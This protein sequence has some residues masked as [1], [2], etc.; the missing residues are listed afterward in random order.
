V[1]DSIYKVDKYRYTAIRFIKNKMGIFGMPDINISAD[2]ECEIAKEKGLYYETDGEIVIYIKHFILKDACLIS[3]DVQGSEEYEIKHVL[4]EG[5]YIVFDHRN[6]SY[7]FQIEI[8]GLKGPTRTLY[9]HTI[10]RENG[11]TLRVEENDL[12]RCAGKYSKDTY[13]QNQIDAASH[14]TFAAREVLRKMGVA[15][16]LHDNKLGY[17]LLLGFETCNELHP[18]Y[19][20]HWHLIFRWPYFCGS[21]APHI[22]LNEEG[23]MTYNVTYIDGIS[24]VCRKYQT[25]EWCKFV[26]MYGADVLAFRIVEDGG[27]ELTSPGGNLYKISSYHKENGVNVYCDGRYKGNLTLKND[28]VKG[29]L[30]VLWNDEECSNDSYTESIEYDPYIGTIMKTEVICEHKGL[31]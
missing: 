30:Q 3:V 4:C 28:T 13:P 2:F 25:A 16:Y 21:Q 29:K 22:Y 14:Y 27:M 23:K 20:P 6:D 5:K 17:I 7:N 31:I 18:D 1:S 10:L 19:P 9:A 12:G 26:D 15:K 24:G 11:L 8:S